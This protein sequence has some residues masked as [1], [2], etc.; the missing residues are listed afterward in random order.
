MCPGHKG[1]SDAYRTGWERIW[2]KRKGDVEHEGEG[3]LRFGLR[4][5]SRELR[6]FSEFK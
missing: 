3:V 1:V 2:G 4:V 6:H 5:E